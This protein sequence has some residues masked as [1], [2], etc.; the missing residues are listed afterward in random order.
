MRLTR[1][2]GRKNLE[3]ALMGG[4]VILSAYIM[5]M[6]IDAAY[7]KVTGSTAPRNPVEDNV[8][9]CRAL[10]WSATTGALLGA[11]K[12]ALRPKIDSGMK[13]LLSD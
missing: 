5:K 1:P 3:K 7:E 12:V 13:K 11:A 8:T 10:L 6:G 2:G 4:A 9:W